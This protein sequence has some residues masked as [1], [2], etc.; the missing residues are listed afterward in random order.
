[1]QISIMGPVH[2]R[3]GGIMEGVMRRYLRLLTTH[4][5]IMLAGVMQD[6]GDIRVSVQKG[7]YTHKLSVF[8]SG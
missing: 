3:F 2:T 8:G 7:R 6:L 5:L 1:M 4:I